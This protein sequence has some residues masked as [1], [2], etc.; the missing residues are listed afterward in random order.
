ME[1]RWEGIFEPFLEF[2]RGGCEEETEES[3]TGFHIRSG[4][5]LRESQ[6]YLFCQRYRGI[7]LPQNPGILRGNVGIRPRP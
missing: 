1:K 2:V 7:R 5:E 4:K 6:E 3:F